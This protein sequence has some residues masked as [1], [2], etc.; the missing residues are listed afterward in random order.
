STVFNDPCDPNPPAPPSDPTKCQDVSEL[1]TSVAVD[2]AGNV[3]VGY[4]FYDLTKPKPEYDVNVATST[5]GGQTFH[6]HQ[7]NADTGTHYMPWV[8][9]QGDGG[10]DVVYYDTPAVVGP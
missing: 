7:A 10:V 2:D 1:F 8:A 9:A 6:A 5:D 4:I 3:Y